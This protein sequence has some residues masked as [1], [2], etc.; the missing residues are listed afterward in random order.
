MDD[1]SG[2]NKKKKGENGIVALAAVLLIVCI[3]IDIKI[4]I[5]ALI[6]AAAGYFTKKMLKDSNAQAKKDENK[7]VFLDREVLQQNFS[8][9]K[10]MPLP[11]AVLD[12]RGHILMY[13]EPFADVFPE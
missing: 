8:I 5:G 13:N 11:Y 10:N 3:F 9:P 6:G 1:L 2:N 4:G 12:M 7:A